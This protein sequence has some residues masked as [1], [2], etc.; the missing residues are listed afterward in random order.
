MRKSIILLV[1][2]YSFSL[3]SCLSGYEQNIEGLAD[4][5]FCLDITETNKRNNINIGR[6]TLTLNKNM[7]FTIE[8]DSSKFSNINGSWDLCC[9]GSDWG[10]Y[11]FK[12]ENHIRQISNT[13]EM[14]VKIQNKTYSLVFT[15]CN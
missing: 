12:P 3:D 11:V 2:I 4:R 10:N 1:T 6:G 7:T 9:K 15:T 8:N 13:P 5:K 14:E